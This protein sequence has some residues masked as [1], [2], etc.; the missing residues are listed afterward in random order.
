MWYTGKA[1]GRVAGE[2]IAGSRK[3]YDPGIWYNS[4]KFLHLEYQTYGMIIPGVNDMNSL[5]WEHADGKHG[6]R[7]VLDDDNCVAGINVMGLRYQHEIC[8]SWIRDRLTL[9]QVLECLPEANFD[10]EFSPRFETQ[11]VRE[12]EGAR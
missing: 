11:I 4:A 7:I 12:F 10:P 1:Q 5:W 9:E 2:N 3:T 6:M 8:E